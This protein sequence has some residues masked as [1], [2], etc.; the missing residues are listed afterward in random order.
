MSSR[1][2]DRSGPDQP[3]AS[4][5]ERPSPDG[6]DLIGRRIVAS[7]GEPW[8]FASSAGDNVLT[9]QVRAVSADGEPVEWLLC[10]VSPFTSDA[11]TVR[12]VAAVRRYAG[13]EPIQQL[14]Q[15]GEAHVHL[16][17]DLTGAPLTASRISTALRT[18]QGDLKHLIGSIRLSH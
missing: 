1:S 2:P 8:D 12:T 14:H 3:P 15:R 17:Y 4:P 6:A 9:G 11:A 13:E 10:D 7:I 18:G 5:Y 16:L